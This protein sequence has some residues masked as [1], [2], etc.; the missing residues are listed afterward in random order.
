M[1]R[2][3][4]AVV[5][6]DPAYTWLS[7]YTFHFLCASLPIL[8]DTTIHSLDAGDSPSGG[9][10][11]T[12]WD[13]IWSCAAT[14]FA[15]TW[16]A[17]HPNIPGMDE[18]KRTITSRRLYIMVLT[19]IAPE[20]II[21]WAARQFF[22]ARAAAKDF[23]DAFG[24][25]ALAH[26]DHRDISESTATSLDEIP[27]SDGRDSRCPNA[28]T[29]LTGQSHVPACSD[30]SVR[31]KLIRMYFAWLDLCAPE[32]VELRKWT[33]THGFFAWM[34]GF[35]LYIDDEPR[36][37][38]TPDDL[39][40]FVREGSVDMPDITEA[41]IEDRSKGDVLSK[42][43][44]VLQLVWFVIQLVAR[45]VQNLPITLL[46]LDTLAVT[47]LT[48][49][50]Y[51]FWW[52]KPK[53]VG[54]PYIVR[55]KATV[56][57]TGLTYVEAGS[58]FND[59]IKSLVDL[60]DPFSNCAVYS[61]RIRALGGYSGH[62]S[63]IAF[64]T[65]CVGGMLF[66]GIHCMQKQ[67]VWR[68]ASLVMMCA[69]V[70]AFTGLIVIYVGIRIESCDDLDW[71][72]ETLEKIWIVILIWILIL[73]RRRITIAAL[74]LVLVVLLPL[75]VSVHLVYCSVVIISLMYIPARVTLVVLMMLSLRS[76]P[77][78]AYDTIAWTKFV[79]HL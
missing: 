3:V 70:G 75:L 5:H 30:P 1:D 9:N 69:P 67:M 35:I 78:G 64:L 79:P 43:I 48:C 2:S 59:L 23:N 40:R 10:T 46:E 72:F 61:H 45:H 73:V 16:T 32:P 28:P 63:M 33:I 31:W 47:S 53:D 11:R 20:L 36:V 71:V 38:L 49:I 29:Q 57:P 65:G 44:A 19:C 24:Q 41:D 14:L 34:G 37:T 7:C 18:G 60:V 77:P 55:W 68:V 50:A 66:A 6:H 25:F 13:I 54:R 39:L 17:I 74:V 12:L 26:G 56:L 76:L 15:A 62:R 27:E 58:V 52:K 22:S 51:G 8:N 4:G 21:L 42:G